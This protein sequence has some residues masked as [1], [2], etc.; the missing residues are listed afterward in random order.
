MA[1]AEEYASWIVANKDKKGTPEFDKV[2]QAYQIARG[3]QEQKPQSMSET[4]RTM[5]SEIGVSKNKGADVFLNSPA[6]GAI[7]TGLTMGTGLAGQVAGGF[8]GIGQGVKN[9]F[10][11][12]GMPAGE[13]V[14]QVQDAMTYQ[15]RTAVGQGVQSGL[16][17]LLGWYPKMADFVGEKAS[18]VAGPAAGAA[19]NTA[20]QIAPS[21]I[22]LA[23]GPI[24]RL[25][26]DQVSTA[27][28]NTA[29]AAP[30]NA[31]LQ[32][33]KEVG[34]VVTPAEARSTLTNRVV[35][36][37]SG[38]SKLQQLAS[39][40]NI[41]KINELTRN[42]LGI[43]DDVPLSI[44]ALETVRKEAGKAYEA[45]RGAGVV[46]S[47]AA[48]LKA[49]DDIKQKYVGAAKSFPKMAKNEIRDVVES[50]RVKNFDASSGVDA[51]KIQRELTDKAFR[52]GDTALAKAH[53]AVADAIE[54]QL[55]R[56]LQISGGDLADFRAARTRIAQ[57]YDAQK[58]LKGNDIDARVLAKP[59]EQG[60]L[61][62]D[63]KTVGQFGSQFKKS[64]QIGTGNAYVPTLWETLGLG[65]V[66]TLGGL[67]L[68]TGASL[69]VLGALVA[70][71]SRPLTRSFATGPLGQRLMV[72]P[73]TFSP[74]ASVG[75]LNSLANNP[76][77]LNAFTLAASQQDEK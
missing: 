71:S 1:T 31:A 68:G 17:T 11:D 29:L 24:S 2:S 52:S 10:S 43:A 61:T 8:A 22:P 49:L 59:F 28:K 18:E 70:G 15:P 48:F 75:A 47:D 58:A 21:L 63:L 35:E 53:K 50:A 65:G 74:S 20:I 23:K 76:K 13:R 45:V 60:R 32:S 44:S 38:Q 5:L 46:K 51:I 16:N 54:A 36:G 73:Q 19:V 69:P 12:G 62:G 30:K 9:L 64:A 39:Q 72:K 40:K 25:Y 67:G 33:A 41:P 14:S 77:L 6:A 42:A 57:S 4:A 3:S 56:H 27:A 55:D 34:L 37:F 7:E 26:Q 66:G